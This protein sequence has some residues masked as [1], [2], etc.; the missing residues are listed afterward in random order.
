VT[1]LDIPAFPH[2]R[3]LVI[4]HSAFGIRRS[5]LRED[6]WPSRKRDGYA[7]VLRSAFGVR[8]S[9]FGVLRL[10]FRVRRSEA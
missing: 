3:I 2:S 7:R 4:R 8:R 1:V 6:H 10:A 9:A 5:I